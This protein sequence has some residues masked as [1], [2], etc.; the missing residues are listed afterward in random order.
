MAT[1]IHNTIRQ[2][3]EAAL[4]LLEIMQKNVHEGT[5]PCGIKGKVQQLRIDFDEVR[6]LKVGAI[7]CIDMGLWGRIPIRVLSINIFCE[8]AETLAV[9]FSF[10]DFSEGL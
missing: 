7:N 1:S 6:D 3:D 4:K 9:N 5:P 2:D 10:A 8:L